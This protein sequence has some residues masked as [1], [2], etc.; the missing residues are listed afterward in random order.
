NLRS[1]SLGRVIAA[2]LADPARGGD[3]ESW[4]PPAPSNRK[5]NGANSGARENLIQWHLRGDR[6]VQIRGAEPR[7]D[8]VRAERGDHRS[9]I[10]AVPDGR[11]PHRDPFPLE[12]LG[13]EFA[14]TR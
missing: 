2:R 5:E 1:A 7:R 9:V 14:Q 4:F 3:V 12:L 8:D 13:R 11:D 6:D 10:R